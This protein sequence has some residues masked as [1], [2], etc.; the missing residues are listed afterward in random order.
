MQNSMGADV[1]VIEEK[2]R[3]EVSAGALTFKR[4]KD[5]VFFA[6]VMDSYG[7]W[8][9]P[10]GH[11]RRGETLSE[12]AMRECMEETGLRGIRLK[13]KLGSID[14]YF[15]DRFVFKGRMIHKFIHYY[16]FEASPHAKVR[17]PKHLEGEKIQEV[18]WIPREVLLERS[19]YKDMKEIVQ[20]AI[21]ATGRV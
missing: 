14:I 11:V 6:M 18:A 1:E 2:A 3:L 8:T 5:G 13:R 12:A 20:L 16:L 19:A 9:F 21:S 17:V 10:K 7:K 15:R 4:G